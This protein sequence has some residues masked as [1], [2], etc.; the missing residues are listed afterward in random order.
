MKQNPQRKVQKTNK[1]FI[2]KEEM[3]RNIEKNMETAEINMDYAGK[4]E[5]E[6]LQEKNERRRHE[7]QKLK[8]EP[9]D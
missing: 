3:I 7:I 2:P 4:E 8:N 5:L 6:H 9:L 1:D